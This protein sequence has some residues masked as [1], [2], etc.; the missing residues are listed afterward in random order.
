[1]DVTDKSKAADYAYLISE[2][3]DTI[4][5]FDQVVD[6][7]HLGLAPLL[8]MRG[9]GILSLMDPHHQTTANYQAPF[10]SLD[11]NALAEQISKANLVERLFIAPDLFP[12]EIYA[13]WEES[14]QNKF[15]EDKVGSDDEQTIIVEGNEVLRHHLDTKSSDTMEDNDNQVEQTSQSNMSKSTA[16][17]GMVSV[18]KK[19]SKFEALTAEA[20]LDMLLDSFSETK[21]LE[22][23]IGEKILEDVPSIEPMKKVPEKVK[24]PALAINFNEDIDELLKET[25]TSTS[26]INVES[27]SHEVNAAPKDFL[28]DPDPTSKSKLLDDFDS[29]LDTI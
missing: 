4:N 19:P 10:L 2:A 16:E 25:S 14:K 3:K 26:I 18:A 24:P 7:I 13:E 11:L 29:W 28:L 27:G 8:T 17:L 21:F 6:D 23:S 9:Q 5:E 22:S 1:M 15:D 12:P 20:E